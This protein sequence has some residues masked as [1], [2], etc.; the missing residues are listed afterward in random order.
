MKSAINN[1]KKK[2]I[3]HFYQRLFLL[4]LTIIV[5][6]SVTGCTKEVENEEITTTI[7]GTEYEGLYTGTFVDNVPNGEGSFAYEHDGDYLKYTGAWENGIPKGNGKLDTNFWL[8]D[9]GDLKR[10]GSYK[11]DT[12]DGIPSGNGTF[13]AVNADNQKYIY[14]GAF[15]KG[16]FHGQ[17]KRYF[18]ESSD[19]WIEE[20]NFEDGSF[21][22]TPY[23]Y[24]KATGTYKEQEYTITEKSKKFIDEHENLFTKKKV[25]TEKFIDHKFSY[26]K[27]AKNQNNYGDKLIKVRNLNVVQIFDGKI[28]SYDTTYCI[29]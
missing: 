17:G 5:T 27:Y 7:N 9:F 28:N 1:D 24:F 8:I 19:T 4:M 18:P 14:E 26:T 6:F 16:T 20:G 3:V 12:L 25:A 29:L 21:I 10:T 2:Q 15:L 13:E 11:G 22:P 23:E